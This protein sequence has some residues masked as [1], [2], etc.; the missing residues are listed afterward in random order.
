MTWPYNLVGLYLEINSALQEDVG[1]HAEDA[2][3]EE[4]LDEEGHIK[5]Y[6]QCGFT[7]QEIILFLAK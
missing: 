4:E 6:F 3:Q 5:Y 7:Y 2:D 1:D